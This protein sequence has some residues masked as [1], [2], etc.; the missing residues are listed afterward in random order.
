MINNY[1]VNFGGSEI[2][3]QDNFKDC[4]QYFSILKRLY[5]LMDAWDVEHSWHFFEPYVEF[6]WISDRIAVLEDVLE[7][8]KDEGITPTLV[9]RP[10]DGVVVDWYC[11]NPE[12]Q[13]FGYKTYAMS[14]KMAMLFWQHREAI[15]KG[16]GERNQF[17]RRPHILANQIGMNY[18]EEGKALAQ[19]ARLCELFWEHGHEEAVRRYEEEFGEKYL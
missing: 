13:E 10:E 2:D 5:A 6:T 12:E 17:M 16:L 4:R 11:K 18:D 19:R 8:L 3:Y 7:L 1:R 9:H 15:E 14:A